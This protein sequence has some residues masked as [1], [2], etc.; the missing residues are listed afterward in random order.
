M[1]S[2][3][4]TKQGYSIYYNKFIKVINQKTKTSKLFYGD[5]VVFNMDVFK[6][7][8]KDTYDLTGIVNINLFIDEYHV[9]HFYI[10][11]D[12]DF[13]RLHNLKEFEPVYKQL[14]K[15]FNLKQYK[16]YNSI[17]GPGL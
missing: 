13:V 8:L 17:F 1:K 4:K 15:Q 16:L 10:V 5:E 12:F 11:S 3:N 7:Q 6:E 2:T 14:Y 9:G